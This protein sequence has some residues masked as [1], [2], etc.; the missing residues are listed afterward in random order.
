[1][2]L[3]SSSSSLLLVCVSSLASGCVGVIAES[4]VAGADDR[5]SLSGATTCYGRIISIHFQEDSQKVSHS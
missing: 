2:Q 5:D 3:S 1:M 4:R